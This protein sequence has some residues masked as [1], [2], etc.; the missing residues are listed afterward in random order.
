MPCTPKQNAAPAS[1]G[2][3]ARQ[4]FILSFCLSMP[5]LFLRCP[6]KPSTSN[7][8]AVPKPVAFDGSRAFEHVRQ[9]VEFGPRP[10]GSAAL[11]QTRAYL[12]KELQSYGL[13]VTQQTFTATTPEG[14]KEMVNLTAELHGVSSE[15]AIMVASH[16]D[17]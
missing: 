2:L 13:Q 8:N 16:Y 6:A 12:L 4:F 9:Q 10:A 1:A 5:F 3:R 15:R 14:P 17:T 11:G 7:T